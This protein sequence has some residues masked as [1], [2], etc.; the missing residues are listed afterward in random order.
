MIRVL[1]LVA[2]PVDLNFI[3][4]PCQQRGVLKLMKNDFFSIFDRFGPSLQVFEQVKKWLI[5][6]SHK[7]IR[8][9]HE[10]SCPMD[11]NLLCD[12]GQKLG[13]LDMLLF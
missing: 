8:V 3:Y 11:F 4:D 7:M 12:T 10:V 5:L 6:N 2:C 1:Y 9:L 13:V